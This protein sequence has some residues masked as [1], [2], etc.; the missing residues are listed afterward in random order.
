MMLDSRKWKAIILLAT[1]YGI[2]IGL[3]FIL[4]FKNI[5]IQLLSSFDETVKWAMLGLGGAIG[6]YI[7]AVAKE[8]ESKP[9]N[10]DRIKTDR[11]RTVRNTA[12]TIDD[13]NEEDLKK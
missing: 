9:Y 2:A 1:L 4:V 12:V 3:K 10:Q 8:K 6:S 11:N 13:R 7:F 5:S